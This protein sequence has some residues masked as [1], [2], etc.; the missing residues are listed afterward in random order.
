MY[1]KFIL[2]VGKYTEDGANIMIDEGWFEKMP[3]AVDREELL[4]NK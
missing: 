4:D 3:E 2:D 1:S